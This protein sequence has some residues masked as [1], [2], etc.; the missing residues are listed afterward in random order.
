M[1]KK[2]NINMVQFYNSKKKQYIDKILVL[3]IFWQT[4]AVIDTAMDA[5]RS[6][7]GG[8]NETFEH[9]DSMWAGSDGMHSTVKR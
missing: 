8:G 3:N 1:V 2:A 4:Q 9:S 6:D 5:K 7:C